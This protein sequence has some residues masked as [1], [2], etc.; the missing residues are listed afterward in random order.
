MDPN[1]LI[2]IVELESGGSAAS[3]EEHNGFGKSK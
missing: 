1:S 2:L 3:T